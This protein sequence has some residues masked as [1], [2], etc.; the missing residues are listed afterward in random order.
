MQPFIELV[1][2]TIPLVT[3]VALESYV[4]PANEKGVPDSIPR[5]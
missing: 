1:R 3:E 4:Y 2:I 5:R